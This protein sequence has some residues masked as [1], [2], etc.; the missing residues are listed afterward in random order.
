MFNLIV[1][2]FY[3]KNDIKYIFFLNM[4]VNVL[5][6]VYIEIRY[7]RYLNKNYKFCLVVFEFGMNCF[8]RYKLCYLVRNVFFLIFV[9]VFD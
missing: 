5:I 8:I 2:V 3:I 7:E 9:Y 1:S 6:N 4:L